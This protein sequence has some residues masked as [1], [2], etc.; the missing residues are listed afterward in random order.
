MAK[1]EKTS[2]GTTIIRLCPTCQT[3]DYQDRRY[4]PRMRVH[5]P[6]PG[7]VH[8]CTVCGKKG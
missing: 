7:N 8:T 5:N 6:C 4:G 2:T 1:G 3:H